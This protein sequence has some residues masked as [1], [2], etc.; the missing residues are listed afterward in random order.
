MVEEESR[1]SWRVSSLKIKRAFC[2]QIFTRD[3]QVIE[4]G[5]QKIWPEFRNQSRLSVLLLP[6]ENQHG[7]HVFRL[8]GVV[9]PGIRLALR[10]L[11]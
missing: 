2:G 9:A 4:L 10:N 1:S 7:R 11:Q 3:G 5:V 6:G 8:D